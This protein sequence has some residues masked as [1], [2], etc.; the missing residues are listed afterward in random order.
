MPNGK[1]PGNDGLNKTFYEHFW[2]DLKLYFINSLK[3]SKIDGILSISQRQAVI[4]LIE[5]KD[6]DKI[7]VKNWR[8]ISLLDVDTKILSKSLAEKLKNV[9]LDLISSNQTAYV[10]NQCISESGRLISNVTEM[11]NI[12]DIPGYLV[13]MDIEKAFDSLDH[14]FLLFAIKKFGFGKNFIHWINVLLNK[15]QSCVING[16]FTTRYFNLEKGAR[17]GDPIS[18]YLFILAVE[19]LFELIKNND[20]T[21]TIKIL[22]VHFSYN[23]TLKVQNNFLDTVKSIQKVLRFWN[24]RMLSLEGRIIIF[25]TLAIS[26]IVYLAFLIV[27]PNS[28]IEELQKIQKTFIWHSSRPKISHKTLCNSFDNGGLKHVDIS[29]KIISLQ[30]SWLRKLCDENFHEWEIIP[31]PSHSIANYL[32]NFPSFTRIALLFQWSRSFLPNY[33]L[34]FCQ[35]FYGLINIF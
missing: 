27:I 1:S 18:A 28:L 15:Q 9:L 5:K 30:Y 25:K 29:S 23:S 22:G 24:R 32:L 35:I 6:R 12:L 31:S 3:H 17:Q 19:V 13:T 33:L 2:D 10:K 8:P 14:D 21:N 4:K 7:F 16:G 34:A 26:K 20:T 11:C